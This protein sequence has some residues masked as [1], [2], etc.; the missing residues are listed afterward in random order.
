MDIDWQTNRKNDYWQW[1]RF[2]S[3]HDHFLSFFSQQG[4]LFFA[5]ITLGLGYVARS[6]KSIN[7]AVICQPFHLADCLHTAT[8]ESLQTKGKL[9]ILDGRMPVSRFIL[10]YL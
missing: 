9:N 3:C 1:Y 5:G 2:L 10:T 4:W 7:F 6:D 8:A